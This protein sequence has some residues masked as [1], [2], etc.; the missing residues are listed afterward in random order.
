MVALA[1]K[2]GSRGNSHDWYRQGQGAHLGPLQLA[3]PPGPP[4]AGQIRQA[5]QAVLGEPAAPGADH[6]LADPQP[7]GDP[8]VGPAP[9]RPAAR[10]TPDELPALT[11]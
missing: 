5:V 8:R 1:V 2:S 3:D 9:G 4:A 6:V 10:S 7:P 11:T